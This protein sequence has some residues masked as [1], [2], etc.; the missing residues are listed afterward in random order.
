MMTLFRI[1]LLVALVAS[2]SACAA[3][4]GGVV[5]TGDMKGPGA[6]GGGGDSC[7][8][9]SARS[10]NCLG[11]GKGTQVCRDTGTGHGSCGGCSGDGGTIV[12]N[13][14]GAIGNPCGDCQGCCDGTAC[15][16]F[17]EQTQ[18]QCGVTGTTCTSCGG[19][20]CNSADGTCVTA[21]SGG[22]SN[23]TGG[24]CGK[25]NGAAHCF[26]DTPSACGTGGGTCT[27]CA[28]GTQCNGG[29]CDSSIDPAYMF[30]VT[31]ETAQVYNTDGMGNCWDNFVGVGCGQ[32][33]LYTC[34]A[35]DPG[36]G[37]VSG[38][39]STNNDVAVDNGKSGTD[40]AATD[41]TSW[42]GGNGV[43]RDPNNNTILI[44]GSAFIKGKVLVWVADYD[45]YNSNDMIGS[46]FI[47]GS[48]L[49][50]GFMVGPWGRVVSVVFNLQ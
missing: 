18:S 9:G 20:T 3:S 14:A 19:K 24:C 11:G 17:G 10:C 47:Q 29:A 30:K 48:S 4:G 15:I 35:Y 1:G 50:S 34:F 37:Y 40:N 26:V 49:F 6:D 41:S 13:D 43:I 45:T 33:D 42:T 28:S 36:T 22:C 27:A 8:P 38:C 2:L 7:T 44:P 31:V 5:P 39:T 32:P 21:G 46:S 25:L 23:C 12:V 16:A